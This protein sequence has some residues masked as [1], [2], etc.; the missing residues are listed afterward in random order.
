MFALPI[1]KWK[2]KK[3]QVG[4]SFS[5]ISLIKVALLELKYNLR[6]P[7]RIGHQIELTIPTNVMTKIKHTKQFSFS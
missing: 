1:V 3:L 7:L 6:I 2:I 5:S 4:V